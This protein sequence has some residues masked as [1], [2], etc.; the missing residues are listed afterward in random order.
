[1]DPL[2]LEQLAADLWADEKLRALPPSAAAVEWLRP[3]EEH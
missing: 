3:I 1:V 2:Q